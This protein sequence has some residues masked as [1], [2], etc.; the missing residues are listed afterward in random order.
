MTPARLALTRAELRLV[1]RLMELE[2]LLAAG[3][4]AVWSHYCE[5]ARTLAAISPQ[6]EPGAGGRLLTTAELADRLDVSSKTI[7][8][9]AKRGQLGQ[10]VRRAK[11]GPKAFGWPAAAAR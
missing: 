3:D 11:R 7:L 10:P 8:R 5:S 6:T 4:E 1:E 9:R 2:P